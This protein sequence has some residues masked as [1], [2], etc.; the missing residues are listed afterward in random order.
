MTKLFRQIK[1]I[2]GLDVYPTVFCLT[3][4]LDNWEQR[5]PR[6]QGQRMALWPI[7]DD[8]GIREY[9]PRLKGKLIMTMFLFRKASVRRGLRESICIQEACHFTDEYTN[10]QRNIFS[11]KDHTVT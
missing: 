10:I 5:F 3:S 2:Q 1:D 4:S 11:V 6:Y 8:T 9:T 7:T